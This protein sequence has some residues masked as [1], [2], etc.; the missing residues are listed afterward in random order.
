MTEL[1]ITMQQDGN[2]FVVLLL[3]SWIG[4]NIHDAQ[5]R[6]ELGKQ[7]KQCHFHAVAQMAITATQQR[8]FD[9]HSEASPW[10]QRVR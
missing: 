4:I 1:G 2:E 9:R 10:R 6:T 7:G 3:Q 8:Q 5:F